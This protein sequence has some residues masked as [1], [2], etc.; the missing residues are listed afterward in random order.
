M[1]ITKWTDLKNWNRTNPQEK[2]RLKAMYGT[3]PSITKTLH[4]TKKSSLEKAKRA[5]EK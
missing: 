4:D 1:K 2:A 3:K 5:L